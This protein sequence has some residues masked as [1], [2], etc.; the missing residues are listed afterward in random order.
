MSATSELHHDISVGESLRPT[1]TMDEW[2]ALRDRCAKSAWATTGLPIEYNW[3]WRLT[4]AILREAM[5]EQVP[6]C[7]P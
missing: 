3:A 2:T 5:P 1:M 7:A 4:D 6:E